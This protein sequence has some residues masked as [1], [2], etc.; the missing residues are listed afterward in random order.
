MDFYLIIR[1]LQPLIVSEKECPFDMVSAISTLIYVAPRVLVPELREV[2]KQLVKKYGK[3]FAK[4]ASSN[5]DQIV[6][7]R[8]IQKLTCQ[9]TRTPKSVPATSYHILLT[10]CLTASERRHGQRLFD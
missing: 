6:N 2:K 4:R 1:C 10:P 9:V 8:I 5:V 3:E 7:E